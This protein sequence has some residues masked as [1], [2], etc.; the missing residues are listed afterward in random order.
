VDEDDERRLVL[1]AC[2][3][4]PGRDV[5]IELAKLIAEEGGPVWYVQVLCDGSHDED[6]SE[7]S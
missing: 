5:E 2:A 7:L 1:L 6:R 4:V 3:I